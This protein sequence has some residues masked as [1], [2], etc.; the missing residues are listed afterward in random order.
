MERIGF[1]RRFGAYLIDGIIVSI[2]GGVIGSGDLMASMQATVNDTAAMADPT[3]AQ[4]SM[5]AM[6]GPFLGKI[7]LVGILYGLLDVF[8]GQTLGKMLLGIGIKDENGS[9]A[10]LPTLVT[11]FA[12]KYSAYICYALVA[13]M[14]FFLFIGQLAGLVVFVGCLMVFSTKKQALHDIVAKTAVFSVR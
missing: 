5:M 9:S 11:R 14:P 6:M 4:A 8:K 2:I 1:G 10:A 7:G 12:V 3:Q 13:F